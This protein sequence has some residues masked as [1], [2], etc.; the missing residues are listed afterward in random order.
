[1]TQRSILYFFSIVSLYFFTVFASEYVKYFY[2]CRD[3]SPKFASY[4][5]LHGFFAEL[6]PTVCQDIYVS[7]EDTLFFD[8]MENGIAV[9]LGLAPRRFNQNAQSKCRLYF[10]KDAPSLRSAYPTSAIAFID[11][12]MVFVIAPD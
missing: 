7:Y 6:S 1:M 12:G 2:Y 10:T 9:R 5:K 8:K 3:Y 11:D 4:Q